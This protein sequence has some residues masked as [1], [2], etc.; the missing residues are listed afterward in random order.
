MPAHSSTKNNTYAATI[1]QQGTT[2]IG[3]VGTFLLP[4]FAKSP[5]H[6]RATYLPKDV[7]GADDLGGNALV[8]TKGASDADLAAEFLT[9]MASTD[10][11]SA[12]CAASFEL[13]TLQ[14]L[15]GKDLGWDLPK[16]VMPVFVDQATTITPSDVAQL[17]WLANPLSRR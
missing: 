9:F 2:A 13:P 7:R 3:A 16:G 11:I 14:G 8:A 10:S 5:A 4:E 1:W 17:S 15:V 6:W 12:F